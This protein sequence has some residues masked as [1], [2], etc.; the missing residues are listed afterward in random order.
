[1]RVHL[2]QENCWWRN[3]IKSND[4]W[5]RR[6]T[7]VWNHSNW[8]DLRWSVEGFE[9][10]VQ[11]CR[12]IETER[13]YLPSRLSGIE[14]H[15]PVSTPLAGGPFRSLRAYLLTCSQSKDKV[16]DKDRGNL[17]TSSD[18]ITT[19]ISETFVCLNIGLIRII[20]TK[21]VKNKVTDIY[22]GY[23]CMIIIL[24]SVVKTFHRSFNKLSIWHQ[25]FILSNRKINE[26]PPPLCKRT[27][28][29]ELWSKTRLSETSTTGNRGTF[30]RSKLFT[31]RS[32]KVQ[33]PW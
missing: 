22:P 12:L 11:D 16:G 28:M 7:Q 21:W 24:Q 13:R 1:M 29:C 4:L 2:N 9:N 25:F 14:N 19:F 33:S 8:D 27:S 6:V 23:Y 30:E 17:F 32:W 15:Y 20:E 5:F 10:L 3:L 18:H 26:P 31:N